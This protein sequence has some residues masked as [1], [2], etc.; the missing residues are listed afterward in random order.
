MFPAVF[1]IGPL[2]PVSQWRGLLVILCDTLLGVGVGCVEG[3]LL[4][5]YVGVYFTLVVPIPMIPP[6]LPTQVLEQ[7][8]H[9]E[10]TVS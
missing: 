7:L 9:G 6:V 4:S 2:T 5:G 3:S 1:V 8:S 10:Y